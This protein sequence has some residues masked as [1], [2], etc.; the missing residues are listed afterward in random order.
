M[1]T[2]NDLTQAAKNDF[3]DRNRDLLALTKN[4]PND[5]FKRISASLALDSKLQDDVMMFADL[6]DQRGYAGQVARDDFKRE[7]YRAIC[8]AFLKIQHNLVMTWAAKLT[9]EALAQLEAIE[10]VA[11]VREA[12][13]PIVPPAPP[14]SAQELLTE[15]VKRDWVHLRTSEVKRKCNNK[16]YKAEF[17]RLMNSGEL[18]SVCTSLHDGGREFRS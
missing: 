5:V 9:P 13:A 1:S 12:P 8:V 4:G 10:V 3:L 2:P 6:V 16:L 15:E 18:A 7:M 11:G 17:D 14:K